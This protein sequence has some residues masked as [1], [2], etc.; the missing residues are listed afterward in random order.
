MTLKLYT[1]GELGE[2]LQERARLQTG[3]VSAAGAFENS[4]ADW[5]H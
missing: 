5:G 4:S 2:E 3:K 1:K